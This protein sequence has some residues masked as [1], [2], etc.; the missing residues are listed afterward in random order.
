MKPSETF[1]VT[2]TVNGCNVQICFFISRQK[3]VDRLLFTDI[4][5]NPMISNELIVKLMDA[6]NAHPFMNTVGF[7]GV[8]S[9][10]HFTKNQDCVNKAFRVLMRKVCTAE[11][12]LKNKDVRDDVPEEKPQ[13]KKPSENS[14]FPSLFTSRVLRS[15]KTEQV[16]DLTAEEGADQGDEND[17]VSSNFFFETVASE[18]CETD[19][20]LSPFYDKELKELPK[21]WDEKTECKQI[22]PQDPIL[23]EKWIKNSMNTKFE[24]AMF[25]EDKVEVAESE[26][27]EEVMESISFFDDHDAQGE[28][29]KKSTSS[30]RDRPHSSQYNSS[31][32]LKTI[33]L[34][35]TF[36]TERYENQ[37]KFTKSSKSSYVSTPK[38]P[39]LMS[40]TALPPRLG[41]GL[42][43]SENVKLEPSFSYKSKLFNS[44]EMQDYDQ[45]T[46]LRQV[47]Q[48]LKLPSTNSL[49]SNTPRIPKKESKAPSNETLSESVIQKTPPFVTKRR[50]INRASFMDRTEQTSILYHLKKPT[51]SVLHQL[52][53]PI[54][55]FQAETSSMVKSEDSDEDCMLVDE[56]V[57]NDSD[58][59]NNGNR[60]RKHSENKSDDK[61]EQPQAKNRIFTTKKPQR[62]VPDFEKK[63]DGCSK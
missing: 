27:V 18:I 59:N 29:S 38:L 14:F 34:D 13:E 46:K 1:S 12:E 9:E 53:K 24:I 8:I 44:K 62:K 23:F 49:A 4:Y 33:V 10:D 25:G 15:R 3:T 2:L 50:P 54:P 19:S 48:R 28:T 20:N 57:D 43:K 30:V 32:K 36:E 11:K 52:R 5:Y 31:T 58:Q 7:I 61:E 21:G 16:V 40:G 63:Y 6:E 17:R 60:K 56:N 35:S 37:Q 22:L 47:E 45:K 51:S 26:T 39:S 41:R 42:N 55:Q